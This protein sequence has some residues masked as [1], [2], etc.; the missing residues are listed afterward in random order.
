MSVQEAIIMV[1][2]LLENNKQILVLEKK[3]MEELEAVRDK[4]QQE[5]NAECHAPLPK[6][7]Y[8]T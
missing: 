4:E 2:A 6:I 5:L 7:H 3:K 8:V 1:Q